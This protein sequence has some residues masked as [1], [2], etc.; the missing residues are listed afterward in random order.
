[1]S[2]KLLEYMSDDELRTLH[3]QVTR[4]LE[5]H[6]GEHVDWANIGDNELEVR[7]HKLFAATKKAARRK[8]ISAEHKKFEDS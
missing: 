8:S 6:S 5:K 2:N 1:M 4:E 3:G 7:K